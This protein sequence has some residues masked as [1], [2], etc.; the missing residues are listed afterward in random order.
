MRRAD[1]S[2]AGQPARLIVQRFSR[3]HTGL[4]AGVIA[5]AGALLLWRLLVASAP[6]GPPPADPTRRGPER[7]LTIDTADAGAGERLVVT[8]RTNL[9]DGAR[10][11]LVVV[12]L[13]QEVA[14]Q[15][16]DVR[17]GAFR[18]EAPAPTGAGSYEA[19][20]GFDLARQTPEV[21]RALSFQPRTL[22]RSAPV[23][24]PAGVAR[25]GPT[26]ELR[27]LFAEVNQADRG[28]GSDALA[29][30]DAE[31]RRLQARPRL[32]GERLAL[33]KLRAALEAVQRPQSNRTEFERL[34]LEAHVLAGL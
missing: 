4:A 33:A 1:L 9:V 23:A 14:R 10:L 7:W 21:Q 32:D 27:A 26:P 34:L 16:A 18:I 19:R 12:L 25:Q 29:R 11:D 3:K 31:A 28:L 8:G 22:V 5:M 17:E 15:T 6:A 2:D 30:L 24:R 20:V 13:G